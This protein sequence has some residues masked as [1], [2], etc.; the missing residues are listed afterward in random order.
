MK[1]FTKIC[2]RV[3]TIVILLYIFLVSISLMSHS[4]KCFGKD[5]SEKLIT[6]TA[7][8]IVGLFIGVL[9]TS[10]IQSSS[11]TTSMVVGFVAGGALSI[12]CAIPIVM[13]ANIG[14]TVTNTL[15][16]VGHITR[17]EEFRRAF[18]SSTMHDLFNMLT[19]IILLPIE[20]STHFLE[21]TSIH[22]ASLLSNT[23][24]FKATSPIKEIVKPI[25]EGIDH[26]FVDQMGIAIK[27]AGVIMLII[28]F[29]ILIIALAG[30]VKIMKDTIAGQSEILFDK[31]L[32]KS[33]MVAMMLG[34]GF[35]AIVQ[36]SSVTTSILVPL[37]GAGVLRP[38][39]VYPIVLGAN[40]GT[41]IT[42]I[43]ASL[44]GNVAA[45]TVAI[46]HVLFNLC[47]II[48]FYPIKFMRAIP[49]TLAKKLGK[50][51]SE[52]RWVA[53]VYVISVFFLLPFILI[54]L[55]NVFNKG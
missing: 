3:F 51:V 38:E 31:I 10:I 52:K 13:G 37:V 44:T 34:C 53:I 1:R 16:A 36:S 26:L 29:V 19:V 2:L 7:N 43:L 23:A 50:V 40:L 49:I 8:P 24:G 25:V 14:T 30:L 18:T 20:L 54:F 55:N 32:A 12:R 15:V 48:L 9:A 42:A 22:I 11:T 28:S 39:T 5:F 4:F 47:G 35:T 41:T 45:L 33:G 46:V 21:R 6:T 17:K 27:A